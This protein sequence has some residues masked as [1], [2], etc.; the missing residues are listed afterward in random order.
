MID[1]THRFQGHGSL[2]FVYQRGKVV[3][4][5]YSALKYI[6]NQ[7]RTTYRAA[8]VVSRKVHKSAVVRNRIRRR[9]Y[10]IIRAHEPAI[11]QPYDLVFTIYNDQMATM[12]AAEVWN[13]IAFQLK[14]AEVLE[15]PA[16]THTTPHAIVES[17]ES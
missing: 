12:P 9:V 1:R 7:R 5:P 14:K 3:R 2:R 8:V 13:A 17:K 4:G 6:C 11:R 10:E 15:G 16:A